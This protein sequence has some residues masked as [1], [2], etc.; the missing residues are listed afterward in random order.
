MGAIATRRTYL[1]RR[2]G[3]SSSSVS[4]SPECAE[5]VLRFEPFVKTQTLQCQIDDDL[6]STMI[7]GTRYILRDFVF[8]PKQESEGFNVDFRLTGS[9]LQ[10]LDQSFHRQGI[11]LRSSH[12]T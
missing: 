12:S 8:V 9:D 3:S 11:V 1:S 2:P 10:E 5:D 7:P 4:L 6:K